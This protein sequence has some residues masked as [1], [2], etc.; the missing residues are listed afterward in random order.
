MMRQIPTA[1]LLGLLAASV[2]AA[3]CGGEGSSTKPARVDPPAKAPAGYRSVANRK[4][5]FTVAVPRT[6]K[7]VQRGD[8]T[9]LKAPGRLVVMT[10]G[11]D[12]SVAGR[13][14]PPSQYARSTLESLPGFEGSIEPGG[15][16][17]SGTPYASG[18]VSGRGVIDTSPRD[19][20]ISVAAL[21]IPGDAT[22]TATIFGAGSAPAV[23][24]ILASIRAAKP[25]VGG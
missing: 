23:G 16:Q 19:Q 13:D 21:H 17:V 5:G 24:K 22:F 15:E 18:R 20:Q 3:G 2:A 1:G 9:L 6:W 14:T 12:R 4:A 25:S 8:A 11:A 10:L 7:A